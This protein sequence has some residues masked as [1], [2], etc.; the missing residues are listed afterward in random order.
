MTTSE[1]TAIT[2]VTTVNAPVEKVWDYWTRPQHIM[3]WNNASDDWH[4]PH[5]END[6]RE[7]GKFVSTMA[8]R[9]GSTSFDFEG[10]YSKVEQHN[11]IEYTIADGRKVQV[12]FEPKGSS[13]TVTETFEAE[14]TH[15]IEMQR[16]GWQAILNNFKKYV[17][18]PAR[19]N[20]LQFE[21]E[22]HAPVEKVF[23]TMLGEKTYEAWTAVF[24]PTS[25]YEGT[26][27]KGTKILFLGSDEKGNEG[28]MVSRIRD[29]VPNKFISIEHIGVLENGKERTTGA[30]V[31]QWAGALEN[32]TFID[33]QGK[34]VVHVDLDINDQYK[35]YFEDLWPR[36]LK[37]LKELCE[38]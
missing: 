19:V 11:R 2:V 17:E 13:T 14:Q 16:G 9:D 6:L 12:V 30:D 34:T 22:I 20:R 8:A 3:Q 1:K 33:K 27:E 23:N 4:T 7:G 37:K 10:T 5:A 38:A 28:G 21:I 18:S 15:T 36:A 29:N 35:D 26:W 32:Y 24:N 25:R 31:E